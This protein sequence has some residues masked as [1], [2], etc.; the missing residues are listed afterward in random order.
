[1]KN[2]LTLLIA[3]LLWWP[4][5]VQAQLRS[6]NIRSKKIAFT[7]DAC[8]TRGMLRNLESGMEKSFY[9]SA[10]IEF[11]Q[12]ERVPATLF[13][14]GLW[15]EKYEK[16]VRALALD[17]LFEIGS[18]SYSHRS[19]VE[20]CYSLP[21]LPGNEKEADI[22]KSQEILNKLT[23]KKPT[24]FRFPGGCYS[25]SDLVLVKK[26]GLRAVGWTLASGDAFNKNTESI[27][28]NIM[29]RVKPGAIV[30]F[31]LHQSHYAPKTADV[32]KIVVPALKKQGYEF[33]TVS[34]L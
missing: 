4:V 26:L 6:P 22:L 31:H 18:H 29:A 9:N 24:L 10:V 16:E 3:T 13:L 1:M 33:T 28:Q 34:N 12:H 19:F 21:I 5:N 15:A 20:S 17:S 14:T 23:G 8:M 2:I 11:L 7:F 25:K 32:L 27:V 30:V